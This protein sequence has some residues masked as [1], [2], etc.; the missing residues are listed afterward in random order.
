M[1][2]ELESKMNEIRKRLAELDG[3]TGDDKRAQRKAKKETAAIGQ[4]ANRLP[5][6]CRR[7]HT[8]STK[9]K[10]ERG[11]GNEVCRG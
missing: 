2:A 5:G 11:L 10:R 8:A 9:G 3:V 7:G 1:I 4:T 6:P